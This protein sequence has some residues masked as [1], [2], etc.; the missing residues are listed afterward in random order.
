MFAGTA[1]ICPFAARS[2]QP[3]Q[4]RRIDVVILY[5]ESD[6]QGQLRATAFRSELEKAG[7]TIGGNLQV[8]FEWGTG[9]A[10][11]VRSTTE[12]A[13]RRAPDV[14]L[15]NGDAATFAA[16]RL[17]TTVPIHSGMKPRR[18]DASDYPIDGCR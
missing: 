14:L 2:Q 6:P 10:G 11:W 17:T 12:Q 18:I 3:Q 9:D 16:R 5:P 4:V 1:A 15:A 13:L 7:W 8:E